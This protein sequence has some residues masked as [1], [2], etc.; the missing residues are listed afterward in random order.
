MNLVNEWFIGCYSDGWQDMT[1]CL[2]PFHCK[3]AAAAQLPKLKKLNKN[4]GPPHSP[5]TGKRLNLAKLGDYFVCESQSGG[6]KFG[7][8]IGAFTSYKKA[9][10]GML[11]EAEAG[12]ATFNHSAQFIGAV[13]FFIQDS[14][15][16][17]QFVIVQLVK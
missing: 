15:N 17:P 8:F 1:D 2:G 16:S 4:A 7:V 13:K 11:E 12:D 5:L 10:I 6:Y 3:E 14:A 9:H